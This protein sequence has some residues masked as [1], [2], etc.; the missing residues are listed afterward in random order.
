MTKAKEKT[1]EDWEKY[2][3]DR[4]HRAVKECGQS[5]NLRFLLRS[6]LTSAGCTGS[7][8]GDTP[9]NMAIQA[10]RQS[11]GNDLIATLLAYEP[12]FY[13]RLLGEDADETIAKKNITEEY[14]D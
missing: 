9:H 13:S 3:E 14:H 10:G 4:M 1:A 2:D 11:I 5:P 6:I 12:K 7:V 8:T